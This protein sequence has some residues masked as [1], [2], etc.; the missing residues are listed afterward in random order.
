MNDYRDMVIAEVRGQATFEETEELQA[1][2]IAWR[3]E[4]AAIVA[5]CDEQFALRKADIDEELEEW[6][7]ESAEYD[8]ALEEYEAWKRKA[9]GFKRHIS[10]R[11]RDVK[12]LAKA[13]NI[14]RDTRSQARAT[15]VKAAMRVRE[16]DKTLGEEEFES[17]L[18]D[19]YEALDHFDEQFEEADR[20]LENV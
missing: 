14:A 9:M 2:P 15:V 3:D 12:R 4:L 1:D 20:V 8:E 6:G 18:A 17:A 5:H 13:H 11:L 10:D 19:L 16:A 7:E